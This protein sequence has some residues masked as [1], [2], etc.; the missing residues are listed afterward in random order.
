MTLQSAIITFACDGCGR[1]FAVPASY[2][3]RKAVCK[4]CGAKVSVPAQRPPATT[5]ISSR[6][7]CWRNANA[8]TE[9]ATTASTA[10]IQ[11]EEMVGVLSS[12]QPHRPAAGAAKIPVHIR[13]LMADAQQMTKAFGSGI[14]PIRIKSAVGDPPEV[15]QIEYNVSSLARGWFGRPK[16]R[17]SHRVEIQLTSEYPR[18]SPICRMLTPIFHPNIDSTTIC[19]GDHWTAGERL[20]D[21]VIR[22]GE[23]LAYQAYNIKSPLDGEAAMWADLHQSRLPTD[24]RDL[25]SADI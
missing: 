13:R 8:N 22:I 23:M 19:V 12:E 15:Y 20:I 5:D 17:T 3:G 2:V 21:L 16:K 14:G 10:L 18:V 6:T 11:S 4:T 1:A 7:G 24:T 25:H 9:G